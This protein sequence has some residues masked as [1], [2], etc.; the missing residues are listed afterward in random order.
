MAFTLLTIISHHVTS[1]LN[2]KLAGAWKLAIGFRGD[3]V[4]SG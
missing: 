1:I 2:F 4:H 3:S